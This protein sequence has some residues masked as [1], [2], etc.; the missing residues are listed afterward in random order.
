M[1]PT[2][3]FPSDQPLGTKQLE[4]VWV[5]VSDD[6]RADLGDPTYD[7]WFSQSRLLKVDQNRAVISAPGSM[8]AIWIEENFREILKFHLSKYLIDL[9]DFSVKSRPSDEALAGSGTLFPELK[10]EDTECEAD[11]NAPLL[12]EA[13]R[14]P[15]KRVRRPLS[16]GEIDGKGRKAGLSENFN[17]ENF[18]GSEHSRL[19]GAA[20]LAAVDNPGVIHQPLYFH[21]GPG[22]GKTHLLHSIGWK[23]LRSNH[24]SKVI[25][26]GAEKFGNEYID[27][28]RNSGESAFRKKYRET[29]LLLIDDV[30]FLGGKSGFQR[31]FYH[32]FNSLIE[33]GGQIVIASDCLASEI[34][35]L[36]DRL[37]CRMQGGMT[38]EIKAP[39][40]SACEAILR[41][42]RDQWGFT[43]SD[44]VLARIVKRVSHNVRQL[45]GA[46]IRVAMMEEMEEGKSLSEELLD[47]VLADIVQ[48]GG[49]R[50]L[51]LQ[52]IKEAVAEFYGTESQELEGKRRTARIAEARQAAMYLCRELTTH[53]LKEIGMAFSKDHT[54]VVYANKV[55]REKLDK[56]ESLRHSMET[57][58][59]RIARL[60]SAPKTR[61]R[62]ASES[63]AGANW[64]KRKPGRL[65]K[66]VNEADRESFLR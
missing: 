18:V 10:Y 8:Y 61:K 65:S 58:R 43:V 26:I 20:A 15:R 45:E 13:E 52:E 7:L 56:S 48:A 39:D 1:L 50:P 60:G 12:P 17:F 64:E 29:D 66:R 47:E 31:E 57:L 21:S 32:T 40:E 46:L 3:Q 5:R 38:V 35:N 59:R 44:E 23:F 11:E 2:Y 53:S 34:P 62:A 42:K 37:I 9:N 14:S 36:E 19:A 41:Q 28:I 22:L 30:Q 4:T 54:S 25:F 27:A 16:S 63:D 6:L 51:G 49:R 55:I 33:K 24:H